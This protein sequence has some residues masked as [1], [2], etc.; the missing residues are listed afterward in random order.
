MEDME[1][2]SL[3]K[4]YK[5]KKVLITGHT[6]FKG[7]WLSIWLHQLGAEVVGYALDPINK[8][9][10]FVLSGISDRIKDIRGD[11]RDQKKVFETFKTEKPEVVFHLAAQPLVI[12]SYNDPVYT[13]ETNIMG[14]INVLEAIRKTNTVRA[15]IFITT[16][17]VYHNKEWIWPYRETDSLGG[18]DPYSSSKA[19]TELVINSYR[20]SFFH[21]SNFENHKKSIASVRAG[22]VIGGGDW[23]ENRIIPDC[24]RSIEEN[25]TIE[26]RNP[27]AT[28]PWQHVLD[29]LGGYLLLGVK[30]MQEPTKYNEAWN[31]GPKSDNF[32]NVQQLVEEL[33]KIYKKGVWKDLSNP[34]SVHEAKL[35]ALDINKSKSILNW[36]PLLDFVD[37]LKLTLDWYMNYNSKDIFDICTTHIN[38]YEK[39]AISYYGN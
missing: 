18:F 10:N 5:N 15:A 34:D 30:M 29:P 28:R 39:K 25:K 12:D 19:A 24:I 37:S 16:D 26:I 1:I 21:N 38:F 31:F 2:I 33:I 9:D 3:L 11:I 6:G 4:L 20:N 36:S 22:N 7:S 27:S 32:I 23:A 14:T 8:K 17:K 13:Y 35:L